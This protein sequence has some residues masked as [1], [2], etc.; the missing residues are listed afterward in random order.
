MI[1]LNRLKHADP[2]FLNP[3]HIE[4]IAQHAETTIRLSNGNEYVVTNTVDEIIELIQEQRA[5]VIAMAMN[6]IPSRFD[7]PTEPTEAGSH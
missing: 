4:W 5:Q 7:P 1:R 6:V 2:L 3:D